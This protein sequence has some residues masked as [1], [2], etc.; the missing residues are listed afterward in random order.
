MDL[1]SSSCRLGK[2]AASAVDSPFMVTAL[3]LSYSDN[4]L[5]G[6]YTVSDGSA[7]GK[8]GKE[9]TSNVSV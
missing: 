8:V 1:C 4:G 6:M 5:F 9:V 2:A 7:A 3:N